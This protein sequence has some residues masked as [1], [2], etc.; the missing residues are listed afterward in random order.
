MKRLIYFASALVM[1]SFIACNKENWWF[2]NTT[3]HGKCTDYC[4]GLP[5]ANAS[6]SLIGGDP[7]YSSSSSKPKTYRTVYTDSDGHYEIKFDKGGG[8]YWLEVGCPNYIYPVYTFPSDKYSINS[9]GENEL[10]IRLMS[11]ISKSSLK[12]HYINVSP[13]DTADKIEVHFL[14]PNFSFSDEAYYYYNAL[15]IVGEF[16]NDSSIVNVY[17]CNPLKVLIKWSVTKNSITTN[18]V[19]S[20]NC[21]AGVTA[22]YNI[23]Y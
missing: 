8:N 12:L 6:V 4:T 1:L 13:F 14:E 11:T 15:R 7:N 17:G 2:P 9:K 16:V 3:V 20:V 23:N 10:K 18:F 5:L 21:T 19:D 22:Q